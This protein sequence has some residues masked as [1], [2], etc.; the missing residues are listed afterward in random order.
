MDSLP[1]LSPE[2][3][4]R[5]AFWTVKLP[6]LVAFLIPPCTCMGLGYFNWVSGVWLL[7]ALAIGITVSWLVWSVQVP[8]WRLWAYRRVSQIQMLKELAVRREYIWPD[9]SIFTRTEIMSRQVR[10]ELHSLEKGS[11][12]GG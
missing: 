6:L 10:D 7:P 3:A 9:E 2:D 12:H 5:R 8:R 4:L 1:N 11:E